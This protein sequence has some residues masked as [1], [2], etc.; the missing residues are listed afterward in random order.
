MPK[1]G[2]RI[3]FQPENGQV[4]NYHVKQTSAKIL[5]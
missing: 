3:I 2:E 4:M 1:K 5:G